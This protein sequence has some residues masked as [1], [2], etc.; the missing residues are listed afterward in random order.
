[1]KIVRVITAHFDTFLYPSSP[2]QFL[3]IFFIFPVVSTQTFSKIAPILRTLVISLFA[4]AEC[5]LLVPRVISTTSTTSTTGAAPTP[6]FSVHYIG[7][8]TSNF[9]NATRDGGGGRV[10][11]ENRIIFDDTSVYDGSGTLKHFTDNSIA[12]VSARTIWQYPLI[13]IY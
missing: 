13:I 2:L 10:N 4:S 9:I 7:Q 5:H 8:A 1:M 6:K 12:F 11:G 3:L